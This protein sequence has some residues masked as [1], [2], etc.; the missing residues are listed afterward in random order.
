MAAVACHDQADPAFA[1]CLQV[2]SGL[3]SRGHDS[4]NYQHSQAGETQR[5][6]ACVI[7]GG[8]ISAT[9]AMQV[10]LPLGLRRFMAADNPQAGR[11]TA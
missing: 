3:C 9:A 6:F 5:P 1:E 7:V 2:G 8:I 11:P 10:L 4:R